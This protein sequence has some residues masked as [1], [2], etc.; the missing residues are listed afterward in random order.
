MDDIRVLILDDEMVIARDLQ[1]ILKKTGLSQIKIAN[2]ADEALTKAKGFLPHILLSD[3]NLE[4]KK[5]DGIEVSRKIQNFLNVH[6]IYVTAHSGKEFLDRAKESRPDNYIIKPFDEE[7]IKI[8]VELVLNNPSIRKSGILKPSEIV[9]LTTSEKKVIR[10]ISE[11]YT[12]KEIA[13]R[14]FISP[15]TVENHRSNITRKLG[16]ESRNNS[17]LT[18]AIKHKG[19]I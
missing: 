2:S 4:D 6:I 18:W 7:Q 14:L 17:L 5:I 11:N 13:E 19:E 8:A 16:L 15:K 3:I 12:S 1:R 10:L 9:E